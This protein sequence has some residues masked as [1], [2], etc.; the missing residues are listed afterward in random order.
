MVAQQRAGPN[1]TCEPSILDH[2]ARTLPLFPWLGLFL[3]PPSLF[4]TLPMFSTALPLV[5]LVARVGVNAQTY[6]A[7]YL[8]S[9]AP[10]QSEQ[11]QLGTNQCGTG[12]NQTSLCQN[13]YG[14]CWTLKGAKA[15]S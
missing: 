10:A 6:S 3:L 12:S 13:A 5:F 9:N 11:G 4:T 14:E 8:P 1:H 2:N 7:T 15:D